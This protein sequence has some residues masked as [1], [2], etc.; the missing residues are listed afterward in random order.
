MEEKKPRLT[1]KGKVRKELTPEAL[2]KLA[3]ARQK[4][5]AIRKE[6]AIRKLEAKVEAHRGKATTIADNELTK[7]ETEKDI[8]GNDVP[9]PNDEAEGPFVKVREKLINDFDEEQEEQEQV[10]LVKKKLSKKKTKIIVEQSSSDTDEFE[11]NDHVVF[12]KRVSRKKKEAPP[13]VPPPVQQEPVHQEPV[14]VPPTIS[15]Q[16]KQFNSIYE[17]MSSGAFLRN[18]FY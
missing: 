3:Q 5:N 4:A 2:D 16:Q 14:Q 13:P 12:V 11:P 9:V 15:R 10:K 6:G 18:R 8:G 1:T 17:N 7:E